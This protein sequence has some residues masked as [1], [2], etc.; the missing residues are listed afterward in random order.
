MK[1]DPNLH[2]LSHQHQ[3]GLALTVQIDRAL[4]D[5]RGPERL[6]ALS[7]LA[8]RMWTVELRGHF[9]VEEQTLFPVVRNRVEPGL[10]ERLIS[11][12]REIEIA[13]QRLRQ[14]AEPELPEALRTLAERL[15]AHIRLEERQLFEQIQQVLPHEDLAELGGRLEAELARVCPRS[16]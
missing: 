2:P 12:H 13:F 5:E 8:E 3:H 15:A 6:T 11:D 16:E 9:E 1:R 14:A 10:V 7:E 4:R